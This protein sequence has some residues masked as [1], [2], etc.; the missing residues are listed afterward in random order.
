M[1]HLILF[2]LFSGLILSLKV[3]AYEDDYYQEE[4]IA[5]ERYDA[6]DEPVDNK[7]MIQNKATKPYPPA[8]GYDDQYNVAP[9]DTDPYPESEPY[10]DEP[11]PV[12][13]A[14]AE[15]QDDY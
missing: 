8:Q 15:Y 3:H 1:N 2:I 10:S 6:Y 11:Y 5:E 7:D 9:A 4:P 12:N 13:D 14:P